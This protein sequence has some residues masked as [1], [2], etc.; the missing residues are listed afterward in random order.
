MS[1]DGSFSDEIDHVGTNLGWYFE[2]K[3]RNCCRS[4]SLPEAAPTT[5]SMYLLYK[6]GFLL[7]NTKKKYLSCNK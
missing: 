1:R 7:P 5:S 6:A 3:S 4:C 2:A